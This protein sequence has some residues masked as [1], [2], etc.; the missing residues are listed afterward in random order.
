MQRMRHGLVWVNEAPAKQQVG[1]ALPTVLDQRWAVPTLHTA[2]L[3]I[4]YAIAIDR[5]GQHNFCH[6]GRMGA[7]GEYSHPCE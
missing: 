6:S 1:W 5:L 3:Q 2:A 4:R 7:K